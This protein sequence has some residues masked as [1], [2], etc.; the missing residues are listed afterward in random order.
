M[1]YKQKLNV[2]FVLIFISAIIL[3][4]L[5]NELSELTSLALTCPAVTT[6][7]AVIYFFYSG[8][9]RALYAEQ[10]TAIQWLGLGIL[11]GF[12]GSTFDNIYWSI[13]WAL[14]YTVGDAATATDYFFQKG[15]YFNI[16]ARQIALVAAGYC[17]LR[18]LIAYKD[19]KPIELEKNQLHAGLVAS[20]A[21]GLVLA[22]GLF[23]IKR[24]L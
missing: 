20:F 23:L 2:S 16:Y 21:G 6:A 19:G 1:D 14:D 7:C 15:A 13:P 5:P 4:F 8:A 22:T 17:H 18:S 24:F 10:K 12:I 3:F 9:G 11:V